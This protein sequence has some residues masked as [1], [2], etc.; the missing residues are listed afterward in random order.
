M[1]SCQTVDNTLMIEEII[2][3]SRSSFRVARRTNRQNRGSGNA[4]AASE[5]RI[6]LK[7]ARGFLR[8]AVRFGANLLPAQVVQCDDPNGE[9]FQ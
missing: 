3:N 2:A 7:S 5:S 1:L 8:S 4:S 9:V 6:W